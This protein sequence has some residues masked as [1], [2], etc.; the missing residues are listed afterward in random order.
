[1][2]WG[3]CAVASLLLVPATSVAEGTDASSCVL[4]GKQWFEGIGGG[5]SGEQAKTMEWW[6]H[7]SF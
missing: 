6:M 7:G 1:M 3:H 2:S 5:I 4:R